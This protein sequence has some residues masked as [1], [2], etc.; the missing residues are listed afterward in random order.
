MQISI[1][2]ICAYLLFLFR[3]LICI[4]NEEQFSKRL[5]VSID[6][7]QR[8]ESG[9][10]GAEELWRLNVGDEE[11]F[12]LVVED[13]REK[14]WIIGTRSL[15][16]FQD[17]LTASFTTLDK[18]MS[19]L[20]EE[21]SGMMWKLFVNFVSHGAKNVVSLKSEKEAVPM[22]TQPFSEVVLPEPVEVTK[23]TSPTSSGESVSP[24]EAL[25]LIRKEFR[26]SQ[27]EF[28]KVVGRNQTVVSEMERGVRKIPAG[29]LARAMELLC[30]QKKSASV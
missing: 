5:G 8:A 23:P 4:E 7:L 17:W 18:G 28:A 2:A 29:F 26:I 19:N 9:Y 16:T 14:G 11:V 21:S 24:Q 13:L 15:V 25:R 22:V 27:K 12:G 20:H 10:G 6:V 30:A 3:K 1:E